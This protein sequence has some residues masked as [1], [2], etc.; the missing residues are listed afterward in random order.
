MHNSSWISSSGPIGF[1]IP[2]VGITD[3]VSQN[4]TIKDVHIL[5]VKD[6]ADKN[7]LER[8]QSVPG[9]L[10]CNVLE[11]LY[12]SKLNL[13]HALA[14]EI[15]KY[16]NKCIMVEKITAEIQQKYRNTWHGENNQCS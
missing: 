13:T 5:I 8:K 11:D 4:V 14:E 10:G 2:T 16:K 6:P 9:V 12:K 1:E 7:T 3:I 15:Q